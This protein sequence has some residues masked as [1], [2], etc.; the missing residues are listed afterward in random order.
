MGDVTKSFLY[1]WCGKNKVTPTYEVRGSKQRQRFL[2]EVRVPGFDY[3]G[4]GDSTNN[5][6]AQ[7]N[8][9]RDFLLYLLRAGKISQSEV[10]VEFPVGLQN[11]G[12]SGLPSGEPQAHY[13]Q[14]Y[15]EEKHDPRTKAPGHKMEIKFPNE[16][17]GYEYDPADFNS[18]SVTNMSKEYNRTTT[19]GKAVRFQDKTGVQSPGPAAYTREEGDSS[20]YHRAPSYS[21]SHTERSE[22]RPS[23]TP[24][25]NSYSLPTSFGPGNTNDV[26]GPSYSMGKANKEELTLKSQSPGPAAYQLPSSNVNMNRA[27]AFYMGRTLPPKNVTSSPGPDAHAAH[28]VKYDEHNTPGVAHG[29]WH[30]PYKAPPGF[31]AE[32]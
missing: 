7:T 5:T 4:I 1:A 8:A 27:P 13:I 20:I 6:D 32:Y 3:V 12:P 9:A 31:A 29:I 14:L 11:P 24:A 17:I 10:P 22:T 28:M 23:G 19:M 18:H 2:C 25:C 30:T 26:N 21:M 16:G 15:S